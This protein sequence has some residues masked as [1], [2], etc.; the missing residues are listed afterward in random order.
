MGV[1]GLQTDT[2]LAEPLAAV[3]PVV[4][5][6]AG[7]RCCGPVMFR[8]SLGS[9]KDLSTLTEVPRES[10]IAEVAE[11]VEVSEEARAWVNE[12]E[13]ARKI[14]ESLLPKS[15]PVVPGFGL[16]GYC[17]TARHVG[18]DFYDVIAL[19][20]NSA[21]LV[22]ADVMG[23]GVPAAL[24]AAMLRTLIRTTAD[25]TTQP[26]DLLGRVNRQIYEELSAVDMFITV[27]VALIEVDRQRLTV[28]SAGHCP[29]LVAGAD[30]QTASISPEGLPLGILPEV[31][32]EE[33]VISLGD[34]AFA[35]LHTDGLT[36]ARNGDG[37]I[38]GETRLLNCLGRISTLDQSPEGFSTSMIE[39]IQSF[40]STAS[41]RDDQ[42][43]LVLARTG[44]LAA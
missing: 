40:Q 19:P 27:Q 18:G 1:D 34:I 44:V 28:A 12:L 31:D 7:A 5:R 21:L 23:K 22:M 2:G 10:V 24:F 4:N 35:M 39:E 15:F 14:Q 6:S 41:V 29:L 20:G 33:T 13:T 36:E 38:F 43:L 26:R 32:F 25:L 11:D 3:V 30:G 8:E 37:E 42:A 17:R 9:E 16:A